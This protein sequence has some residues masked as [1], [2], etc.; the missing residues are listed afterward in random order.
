MTIDLKLTHIEDLKQYIEIDTDE[1]DVALEWIIRTVSIR[2]EKYL[3]RI[4]LKG[5]KTE[6]FDVHPRQQIFRLKAWPIDT[7]ET[8]T[9]KNDTDQDWT[10]ATAIEEINYVVAPI[11]GRLQFKSYSVLEGPQALQVA[12]TG[13]L[14][15]DEDDVPDDIAQLARMYCGE[16]WRR[17]GKLS[18]TRESIGGFSISSEEACRMPTI[19][20]EGLWDHRAPWAK[21]GKVKRK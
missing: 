2:V 19:V 12:Y 10:G 15:A 6:V 20:A 4:L 11:Y 18:A 21:M 16:I 9:V 7:G 5:S 13:G 1:H 17:R 3:G 14:A 8:V